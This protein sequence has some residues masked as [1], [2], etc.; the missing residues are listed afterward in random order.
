MY[1]SLIIS[2]GIV[3]T[4]AFI[5]KKKKM[6]T[7][8]ILLVLMSSIFI[9][10]NMAFLLALNYS[11][12]IIPDHNKNGFLAYESF[13]LL[14]VPLSIIWLLDI[15]YSPCSLRRR[16]FNTLV[17][18][19]YMCSFDYILEYFKLVTH[20]KYWN[21]GYSIGM[22]SFL[23][24]CVFVIKFFFHKLFKKEVLQQ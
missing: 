22:Y 6:H 24:F 11:L 2:F 20:N 13:R 12:I 21:M 15:N 16:V 17:F 10:N 3:I 19:L 7:L 1:S 4:L 23:I 14:I 5:F 18:L 8:E 9:Y